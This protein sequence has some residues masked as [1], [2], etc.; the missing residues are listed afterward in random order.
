MTATLKA[1]V[2]PLRDDEAGRGPSAVHGVDLRG[3]TTEILLGV[4]VALAVTAGIQWIARFAP[5]ALLSAASLAAG[6]LV[7]AAFIAVALVLLARP[8]WSRGSTLSAWVVLAGLPTA[9]QAAALAGT[10]YYLGGMSGDQ[11][12]RTEYV[13]RLASSPRLA[14]MTYA[15]LPPYYPATWFWVGARIS[16]LTG[17]A[18]WATVKPYS[19]ATFA[20][21]GIVVFALWSRITGRRAALLL[22]LVTSLIGVIGCSQEPYSW[23][24]AATIPPLAVLAWQW[25]TRLRRTGEHGG[26]GPMVLVGIGLGGYGMTYTLLFGFFG[27]V[28]AALGCLAVGLAWWRSQEPSDERP[29]GP[30]VPV[31]RVAAGT[32]WAAAVTAV[33]AAALMLPVWGPYLVGMARGLHGTNFAARYLPKGSALLPFP[34]AQF[35]LI[36]VLCLAGVVWL[37]VRW[38]DTTAQALAV[39]SIGCYGWYLGSTVMLAADT[40]LLP[41]RVIPVLTVALGCAGLLGGLEAVRRWPWSASRAAARRVVGVLGAIALLA[42]SQTAIQAKPGEVDHAFRDYYPTGHNALGARDPEVP[43]HWVPQVRRTLDELTGRPPQDTVLLTDSWLLLGAHPYWSFQAA[44]PHYANPAA[45]YPARDELIRA[46]AGQRTGTGLAAALERSPFRPPN[47]FV[48]LRQPDGLQ[49]RVSEDT[50][51]ARP[52]IRVEPV[53]FDY[54]AFDGAGFVR[55]DVGPYAVIVRR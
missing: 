7:A 3:L 39:V 29:A 26:M 35:T 16:D 8:G 52:N 41:F 23:P 24:A 36:G 54:K 40:T 4:L 9:C 2:P 31:R 37:A 38:R 33:I 19:L 28:L 43:D 20:V 18:P 22:A 50:F 34:M 53:L 1:P 21:T 17:L 13:T 15:D 51:P 44:T 25:L 14:D 30:A 55:R 32:A 46:W 10:R 6:M 42:V 45:D 5:P 48:L 47:A 27:A 49:L 11:K 12:F